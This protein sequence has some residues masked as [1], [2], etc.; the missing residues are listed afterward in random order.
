MNDVVVSKEKNHERLQ[1]QYRHVFV[2]YEKR[3]KEIQDLQG[4]VNT[5]EKKVSKVRGSKAHAN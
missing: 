5:L 4:K 3:E 2:A 1:E